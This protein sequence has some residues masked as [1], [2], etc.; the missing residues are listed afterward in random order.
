MGLTYSRYLL[1]HVLLLCGCIATRFPTLRTCH[2]QKCIYASTGTSRVLLKTSVLLHIPNILNTLPCESGATEQGR[3]KLLR[4]S[5]WQRFPRHTK[6]C[7]L[8]V[9]LACSRGAH[10]SPRQNS[11]LCYCLHTEI[12]T[13]GIPQYRITQVHPS[14]TPKSWRRIKHLET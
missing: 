6:L 14:S 5:T 7:P 13:R 3:C 10:R 8:R 1:E 9:W 4:F 11:K 12:R 2:E